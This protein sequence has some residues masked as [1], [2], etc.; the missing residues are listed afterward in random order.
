MNYDSYLKPILVG[1]GALLAP[2]CN[3]GCS[4]SYWGGGATE[5]PGVHLRGPSFFRRAALDV[6]ADTT[7]S[8][9]KVQFS[10]DDGFLL[11]NA[12]FGQDATTTTTAQIPKID[13]VARLQRVQVEY[14][15]TVLTGIREIVR[16][17]VPVFNI[18][19]AARVTQTDSGMTFTLPNGFSVGS[20]RVTT[21][22]DLT[23]LFKQAADAATAVSDAP[24]PE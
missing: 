21:P 5:N 18:L 19:A 11:E 12:T 22:A 9:A 17:L 23:A 16:E 15:Q 3:V 1:L 6:T 8:V 10:K 4:A 20:R 7:A 24:L 14:A 13:A 2:A